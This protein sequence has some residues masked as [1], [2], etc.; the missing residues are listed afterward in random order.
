M[1]NFIEDLSIIMDLSQATEEQSH[2]PDC[3][4][5]RMNSR[6]RCLDIGKAVVIDLCEVNMPML[7]KV[8]PPDTCS[9]QVSSGGVTLETFYNALNSNDLDSLNSAAGDM[10]K[11][12]LLKKKNQTQD[13]NPVKAVKESCVTCGGTHSYRNCPSTDGNI[14]RDNIQEY[15]THAA[16]TNF[17]QGNYGYRAPIA[18]QI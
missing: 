9:V 12:L 2:I 13:P 18:N 6:D 15:V 10:V 14:Y 5:G 4:V 3:Q 11:A 17:N 7:N 1:W 8:T 16:A